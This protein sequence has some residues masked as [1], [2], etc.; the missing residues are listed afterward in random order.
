MTQA[1]KAALL[2]GLIFPGAGHMALK[3]YRRGSVLMLGT[4][5][6]LAV[7][8]R[9]A[10]QQALAVVDRINIGEFAVDTGTIAELVSRSTSGVETATLNIATLVIVVCWVVGI[11]DSYRLGIVLQKNSVRV[12]TP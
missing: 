4:L 1:I 2:S 8:I 12:P 11:V 6:A 3:Q 7:I 10:V 9:T 5:I